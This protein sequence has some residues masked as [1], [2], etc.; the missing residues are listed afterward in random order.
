[1]DIYMLSRRKNIHKREWYGEIVNPVNKSN[2]LVNVLINMY[3]RQ[4]L[5]DDEWKYI[6]NKRN[7]K[8]LKSQSSDELQDTPLIFPALASLYNPLGSLVSQTFK[9]TSI[10]TCIF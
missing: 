2:V 5:Q 10:N 8:V 9:G 7:N 6:K 1:M 3:V 4:L